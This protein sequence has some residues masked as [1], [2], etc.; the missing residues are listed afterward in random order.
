[1]DVNS[2]TQRLMFWVFG[3]HLVALILEVLGTQGGE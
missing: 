3:S 2:P 1:M